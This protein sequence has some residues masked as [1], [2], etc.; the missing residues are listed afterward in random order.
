MARRCLLERKKPFSTDWFVK[1]SFL[2]PPRQSEIDLKQ[3]HFEATRSS[4]PGGQHVNKTSTAI[5]ATYLPSGLSVFCQEERSQSRNK[6]LATARLFSLL[7]QNE[8]SLQKENH[9][10]QRLQHYQ[11]ERG[12]AIKTFSG[13]L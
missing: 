3:I 9:A 8:N 2:V 12:N 7:Q 10:G 1:I 5:R 4:G 13:K 11:L 6:E